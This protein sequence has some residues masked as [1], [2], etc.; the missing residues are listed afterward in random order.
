MGFEIAE[1]L[2]W[3]FPDHIV[4]PVAGGTLLPRI[5][6]GL[7]EMR[8]VGLVEGELPHIHAAQPT[9]SAPVVRAIEA[10]EDFPE[11]VKPNTIAKSLAIGNPADGFQVVKVVKETGGTGAM[12]TDEEILDAIQLLASTEG[13]FTEP[14]GGT[15]LAAT[16]ALVRRGVIKPNESVVVCI[17]GNGYKTAE[18]MQDRVDRPVRIGKGLADFERVVAPQTVNA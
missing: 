2:G 8:E 18:V 13:I 12:V 5:Y 4:S 17:T 1:Q 14:A 11:P 3:R 15:T 16:R 7:R 9:G 6:K 10:G